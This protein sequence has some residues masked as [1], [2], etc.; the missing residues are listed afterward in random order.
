MRRITVVEGKVILSK[1][2]VV[3]VS[4]GRGG[5]TFFGAA[6]AGWLAGWLAGVKEER[7][8]KTTF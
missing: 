4:S 2:Q 6:A 8:E 1:E 7:M 3:V 5:C